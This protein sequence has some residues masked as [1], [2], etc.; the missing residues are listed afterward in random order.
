[1][2]STLPNQ[3]MISLSWMGVQ[4]SPNVCLTCRIPIMLT[5]IC[6]RHA[7]DRPV[8]HGSKRVYIPYL[9]VS[10]RHRP[11]SN[12]LVIAYREIV[13]SG[14]TWGRCRRKQSRNIWWASFLRL[15]VW[16]KPPNSR[17]D[18]NWSECYTYSCNHI[19]H[20]RLRSSSWFAGYG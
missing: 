17:E 11:Q 1:M 12:R 5:Y 9:D 10:G 8:P 16:L 4:N 13:D 7:N 14:V 15:A 20:F 19:I 2:F 6:R 18:P 3:D